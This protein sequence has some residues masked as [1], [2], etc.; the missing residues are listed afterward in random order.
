MAQTIFEIM[1][2]KGKVIRRGLVEDNDLNIDI[3]EEDYRYVI[4]DDEDETL[5]Y[6]QGYLHRTLDKTGSIQFPIVLIEE[7]NRGIEL[8]CNTFKNGHSVL[9]YQSLEDRSIRSEIKLEG[10]RVFVEV[11]P[12]QYAIY[13]KNDTEKSPD[14]I[15]MVYGDTGEFL[16]E[17]AKNNINGYDENHEIVYSGMKGY[18]EDQGNVSAYEAA[19]RVYQEI[20]E[21][22]E[23]SLLIAAYDFIFQIEKILNG[24]RQ[25][26]NE[27]ELE[28]T[29]LDSAPQEFIRVGT[30]VDKVLVYEK[31]G[32][33]ILF[34][35]AIG[36]ESNKAHS[37][38]LRPNRLHRL[39]LYAVNDLISVFF[40][41]VP[42]RS[43]KGDLWNKAESAANKTG[44]VEERRFLLF[45]NQFDLK[46]EDKKKL[47]I[48][49]YKK[50]FYN[51][52]S[53]PEV[54]Y[55][56][57]TIDIYV[58]DYE[59]L[60]RLDKPLYVSIKEVSRVF[61]PNR[62][63]RLPISNSVIRVDLFKEG[64]FPGKQ[65]FMWIEDEHHNILSGMKLF[66]TDE[67][68][69]HNY[70][71]I[72]RKAKIQMYEQRLTSY[73]SRQFD[74]IHKPLKDEIEQISTIAEI[75]PQDLFKELIARLSKG[76]DTKFFN[77]VAQLI[78]EE[79]FSSFVV[80]ERFFG[81]SLVF[82][83][84]TG[85]LTFPERFFEYII[86]IDSFSIG[87]QEVRTT[88]YSIKD[89]GVINLKDDDY[90]IISAIDKSNYAKSGF[91]FLNTFKIDT[92]L[93]SW[94]LGIEVK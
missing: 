61:Y 56:D 6:R 57:Q 40:L 9:C 10:P 24:R 67:E 7:K 11:D 25:L 49:S 16:L 72:S 69:M 90:F 87:D 34:T 2:K 62:Q 23:Q 13:T 1:N 42:D 29:A 94:K 88:Y 17:Q 77:T 83:R 19:Q 71:A 68:Y 81:D 60:R 80:D 27:Q 38:S 64:V 75:S 59:M 37:I 31:A 73:A 89:K 70:D 86:Q 14:V 76:K 5:I 74:N 82:E 78:L 41:F 45:N 66:T 32:N 91:L 63:H 54:S 15:L 93:A 52:V 47:S 30:K 51:I 85:A 39:D 58:Q 22:E 3:R 44:E 21:D 20:L 43:V 12:G 48:E 84:E 50:P 35:Y 26:S 79:R 92:V 8:F 36:T 46:D 28:Y 4:R 33:N 65:Y 53:A 18:L 55:V